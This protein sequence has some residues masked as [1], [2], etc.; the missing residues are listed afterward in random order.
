MQAIT[1]TRDGQEMRQRLDVLSVVSAPTLAR[2]RAAARS[3]EILFLAPDLT[4]GARVPPE[5]SI[6]A[7]CNL[8]QGNPLVR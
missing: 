8:E 7:T 2:I 1:P 4:S 6:P 3:M 5:R